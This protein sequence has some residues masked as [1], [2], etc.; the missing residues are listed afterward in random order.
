MRKVCRS[1]TIVENYIGHQLAPLT[2]GGGGNRI[3]NGLEN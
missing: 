1:L 3:Q 2:L